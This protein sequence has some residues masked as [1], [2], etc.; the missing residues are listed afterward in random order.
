MIVRSHSST[1]P[2]PGELTPEGKAAVRGGILGNYVDM[3][4]VFLPVL[5]LAP[6]LPALA[7]PHVGAGSAAIVVMATLL[8]RPAGSVVFGQI[9]DRIG[10]RRTTLIAILG[11]AASSLA[12]A[13]VPDHHVLGIGTFAL[14]IVF[15]VAGGMFLAGEYTSAIPLAME[16]SE[17]RRRGLV[18]G[19]I[20]SMAPWAQFTI[21][22]ATAGLLAVLGPE[23]YAAWGWR[24]S[25]VAGALGSLG[26][27]AYYRR[28]VVDDAQP[29]RHQAHQHNQSLGQILTGAYASAF[30]QMFGLMS[31][32]WILTNVVVVILSGRLGASEWS[33]GQISVAMGVASVA[34]ALAMGVTGHLSTLWGR[35]RFFVVWG[36]LTVLCAPWIWWI[37]VT[38]P[39]FALVTAAAA[40]LQ[41]VTVCAYG[42][43]GAYLSE[44][45]PAH[46]R[47]TGYGSAYSLSIIIPAL[48]PW[49]LPVLQTH[50]GTDGAVVGLL[51]LGGALVVVCGAL[52]P[53][54]R[55]AD[56]NAPVEAVATS[57]TAPADR[58]PR[59]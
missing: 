59:A 12:V 30:W 9:A 43:V 3:L 57:F 35:R 37:A 23:D 4:H 15:R 20:M 29:R 33:A 42:P 11:T 45:F 44:R 16:F 55:P 19:L 14:I 26:V 47:S 24:V 31:G 53:A 40:A 54:L 39:S 48:Y 28:H 41:A 49:Y 13:A 32:L 58:V 50:L 56:L 22:F 38:S 25:F 52:G 7:G 17:P 36:F 8:A 10:R 18:S 27:A 6:A 34:Q 46:I 21:A 5:A 1:D 51:V 2:R